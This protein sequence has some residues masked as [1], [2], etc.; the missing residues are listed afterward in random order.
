MDSFVQED[1]TLM[2]NHINSYRRASL[3]D[4]SPYEVFALLYGEDVLRRMN[5]ELIPADKVTL[6]PFLLKK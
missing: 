1:I 6:R 3:G 5:A 2:M 4:K